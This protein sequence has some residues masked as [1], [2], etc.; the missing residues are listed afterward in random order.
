MPTTQKSQQKHT[1]ATQKVGGSAKKPITKAMEGGSTK[2]PVTKA[3]Q[4]VGGSTKKP[5]TKAMEGGKV[6]PSKG[7]TT[8]GGSAKGGA[9]WNARSIK[10]ENNIRE[11][12]TKIT[13]IEEVIPELVK[14]IRFI[15]NVNCNNLK[16]Q[17]PEEYMLRELQETVMQLEIDYGK[18]GKEY[19]SRSVCNRDCEPVE[20]PYGLNVNSPK[21]TQVNSTIKQMFPIY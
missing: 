12:N 16:K 19:R 14:M 15:Y 11:L 3:T 7:K 20:Y 8:R 18:E 13:K 1:K 10:N 2:K 5:V 21:E 6:A 17:Y 9:L 4:K